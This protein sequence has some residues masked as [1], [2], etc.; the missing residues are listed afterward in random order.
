M[1]EQTPLDIAHD[2]MQ[3][4]GREQSRLGFY[5]R[6]SDAELFLLLDKDP[7]GDDIS[8]TVFPVEDQK[9]VLVFDRAERLTEFTGTPSPYAAMSGRTIAELLVRQ[10]IGLGVNLGVAP[11]SILIPAEAVEW[12]VNT[13]VPAQNI[14]EQPNEITPPTEIPEVLL[15]GLNTK[16]AIAGGLAQ[17]AY[18]VSAT[19]ESGARN[20]LIAFVDAIPGAEQSLTQAVSEALVFSGIE[21]GSIDV[22]FFAAHDPICAK[23]ARVGLRFDLPQPAPLAEQPAA[24]GMDP[25]KPPKLR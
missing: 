13:E 5:E 25:D 18:L 3:A 16:L 15:S 6:L 4:D 21:V 17:T 22:A 1:S 12:L 24:P 23:L 7:D 2:A 19:Y 8:P 20:T 10:G 9:F 14:N 11:S